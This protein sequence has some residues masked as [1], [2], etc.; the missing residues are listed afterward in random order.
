MRSVRNLGFVF[1]LFALATAKVFVLMACGDEASSSDAGSAGDGASSGDAGNNAEGSSGEASSFHDASSGIPDGNSGST[2]G[3]DGG[4]EGAGDSPTSPGSDGGAGS[5]GGPFACNLL[6]G[7]SATGEWFT[8]Y[9]VDDV[10]AGTWEAVTREHE[11]LEYWA[12]LS[13]DTGGVTGGAVRSDIWTTPPAPACTQGA[14]SPGRAVFVAFAETS[15]PTYNDYADAGDPAIRSNWE[16]ALEKVIAMIQS[17]Y[18]SVTRIEL[19][20]MIRGP[21]PPPVSG[22]D[23]QP[24]ATTTHEDVV[25]PWVDDAFAAEALQHPALVFV[26]PRFYVGACNW[27]SNAGDTAGTGPH[28]VD[29]GQPQSVA[30]EVSAYYN[31]NP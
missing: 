9:F 31:A 12:G 24:A 19:M 23:C 16:L 11:Y 2:D 21:G 27:F 4:S 26:A 7:V 17:K 1:A 3:P 20:S 25:E 8:P 18:P 29:G 5:E 22:T 14:T 10:P 28:F 13:P 6:L 30:Q 15:N